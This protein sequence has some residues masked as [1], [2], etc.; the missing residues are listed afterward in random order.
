[1]SVSYGMSNHLIGKNENLCLFE[2]FITIYLFM[3]FVTKSIPTLASTK[4]PQSVNSTVT[5]RL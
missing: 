4:R 5:V 2:I 1:M 3:I